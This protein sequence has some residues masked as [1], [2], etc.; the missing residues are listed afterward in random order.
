MFY[1]DKKPM[2]K[3]LEGFL[4]TKM[5]L[6]T[7]NS[8]RIIGELSAEGVDSNKL[9]LIYN[10][11]NI[12]VKEALPS[13]SPNSQVKILCIANIIPYKG[14]IDLLQSVGPYS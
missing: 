10:G 3:K 5:N 8:E 2:L 7:G 9:D 13:S 11:V 12:P 1:Q 4:H 14:H 6:I